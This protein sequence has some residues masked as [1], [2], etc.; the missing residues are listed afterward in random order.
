MISPLSREQE[1]ALV[2]PGDKTTP[3]TCT[4]G[5][6]ANRYVRGSR[7]PWYTSTSYLPSSG[8]RMSGVDSGC[9]QSPALKSA[10]NVSSLSGEGKILLPTAIIMLGLNGEGTMTVAMDPKG[11]DLVQA[12]FI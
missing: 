5:A 11:C 8:K 7:L 4:R 12:P 9:H 10:L 3:L 2:A 1:A 6:E